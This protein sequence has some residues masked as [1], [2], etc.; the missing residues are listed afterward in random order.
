MKQPKIITIARNEEI[1]QIEGYDRIALLNMGNAYNNLDLFNEAIECFDKII[2]ND[3]LDPKA[4]EFKSYSLVGLKKLKEALYCIEEAV[5]LL[6]FAPHLWNLN[7][8]TYQLLN[9][10]ESAIDCYTESLEID[11]SD[12]EIWNSKGWT[13]LLIK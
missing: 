11:P 8:H 7:G 6:P 9:N 12:N 5:S 2:K 1:L 10:Y 4:W 13:S 3:P